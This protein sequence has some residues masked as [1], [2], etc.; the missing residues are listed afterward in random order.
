MWREYYQNFDNVLIASIVLFE[1]MTTE[2]WITVMSNG[3]DAAGI[4]KQPIYNNNEYYAILFVIFM[5]LG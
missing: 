3:I 2:G 4:E 5:I 1:M